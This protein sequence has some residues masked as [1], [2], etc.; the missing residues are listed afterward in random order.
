MI[1]NTKATLLSMARES[2]EEVNILDANDTLKDEVF[3]RN[4]TRFVKTT[5]IYAASKRNTERL[6]TKDGC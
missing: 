4:S 5:D 2:T 1:L 6:G 3:N